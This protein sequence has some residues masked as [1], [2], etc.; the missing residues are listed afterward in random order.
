MQS[1]LG[2][3]T[4]AELHIGGIN[5]NLAIFKK[6]WRLENQVPETLKMKPLDE[7]CAAELHQLRAILS[8][9]W[10]LQITMQKGDGQANLTN[11][12]VTLGAR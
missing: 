3:L 4:L 8:G 11:I 2:R 12:W 9:G 5:R 6:S 7:L 1:I 10:Q